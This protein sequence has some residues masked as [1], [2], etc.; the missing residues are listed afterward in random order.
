MCVC[1]CLCGRVRAWV[2]ARVRAS[3]RE[4]AAC[5]VRAPLAACLVWRVTCWVWRSACC[6]SACVSMGEC[7]CACVCTGFELG[8]QTIASQ[9]KSGCPNH[10]LPTRLLVAQLRAHVRAWVC[11]CVCVR[12]RVRVPVPLRT[13]V[14]VSFLLRLV[15]C[16]SVLTFTRRR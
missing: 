13:C 7:V 8:A 3:E 11:G 16:S 4:H 2:R 1:L 15:G 14:R 10:C 6:V 12:A 9:P 5:R